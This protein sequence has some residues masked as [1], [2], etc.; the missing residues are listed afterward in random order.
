MTKFKA[1]ASLAAPRPKGKVGEKGMGVCSK[2]GKRTVGKSNDLC[3]RCGG[4]PVHKLVGIPPLPEPRKKPMKGN[5]A[6]F[7]QNGHCPKCHKEIVV[8]GAWKCS[9]GESWR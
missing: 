5:L 7:F 2:C 1:S 6:Q 9:C 4:T 3:S 8:V